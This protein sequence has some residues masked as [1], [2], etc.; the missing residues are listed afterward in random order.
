[1]AAKYS[2]LRSDVA[3]GLL[4]LPGRRLRRHAASRL[5]LLLSVGDNFVA[6][7]QSRGDNDS[8]ALGQS[9]LHRTHLHDIVGVHQVGE[10]AVRTTENRARRRSDR[11]LTRFQ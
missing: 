6:A 3:V 2:Y 4:I 7:L 10:G 11:V 8:T 9:D 1:M 5:Q